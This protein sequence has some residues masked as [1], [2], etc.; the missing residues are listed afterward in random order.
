[1]IC[2]RGHETETAWCKACLSELE[3]SKEQDRIDRWV[4]QHDRERAQSLAAQAKIDLD[5]YPPLK[6]TLKQVAWACDL[7]QAFLERPDLDEETRQ[8]ALKITFA[9]W[10]INNKHAASRLLRAE[11]A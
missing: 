10:W 3:E 8:N 4:R 9:H 1:M 2:S 5:P 11:A 6:G 7:R